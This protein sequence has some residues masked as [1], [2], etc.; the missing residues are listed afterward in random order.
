MT[1]LNHYF[2]DSLQNELIIFQSL[3]KNFLKTIFL[4]FKCLLVSYN[5]FF[6]EI[7]IK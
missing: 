3:M 6:K 7:K 4:Y 2:Y 1:R 5:T